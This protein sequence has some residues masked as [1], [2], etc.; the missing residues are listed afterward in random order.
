MEGK[1][2]LFD[3]DGTQIGETFTRRARQLVKQQRA[4]WVDDNHTAIRFN[5]DTDEDIAIDMKDTPM[6]LP[7][8]TTEKP[9]ASEKPA[10]SNHLYALAELRVN[11]RRRMIFHLLLLIP[12]FLVITAF[13]MLIHDGFHA[14]PAFLF[15]GF[16]NGVLVTFNFC[17]IRAYYR[18]HVKYQLYDSGIFAYLKSRKEAQL[19]SEVEKLRRMGY[20]E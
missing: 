13:T 4:T 10:G 14:S 11:D 2:V 8:P 1:V 18:Q 15:F 9:S 6:P 20:G 5:P 17:N 7:L 19:S 16:A 3:S 12:A